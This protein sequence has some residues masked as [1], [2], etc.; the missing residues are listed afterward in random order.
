MMPPKKHSNFELE[1]KNSDIRTGWLSSVLNVISQFVPTSILSLVR[2]RIYPRHMSD[3]TCPIFVRTT[4][5]DGP[6]SW[7][8]HTKVPRLNS[9]SHR[10]AVLAFM[11]LVSY[12]CRS[13]KKK[14][15]CVITRVAASAWIV[16]VNIY[17]ALS[18]R[19]SDAV[20]MSRTSSVSELT[21]CRTFPPDICPRT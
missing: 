3:G 12:I 21:E 15:R 16:T 6:C 18:R 11:T 17:V 7:V 10:H 1:E 8:V 9:V 4:G 2:D 20:V 13:S 5:I 14:D 19:N